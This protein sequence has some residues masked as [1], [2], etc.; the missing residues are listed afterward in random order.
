MIGQCSG[1]SRTISLH[2]KSLKNIVFVIKRRKY[3][4]HRLHKICIHSKIG[5]IKIYPSTYMIYKPFPVFIYIKHEFPAFISKFLDTNFFLYLTFGSNSKFLLYL[6]FYW[7][8]MT[9]P[10]PNPFHFVSSHSP[11][12]WNY[13]FDSRSQHMPIMRIS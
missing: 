12:S 5:I 9:V 4:H 11:V 3:V 13:I 10:S 6:V 1:T 8:T 7:Q 2:F